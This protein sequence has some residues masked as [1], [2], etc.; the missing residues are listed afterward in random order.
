[1]TA[2][3]RAKHRLAL[4]QLATRLRGQANR[5]RIARIENNSTIE[6][7]EA[8]IWALKQTGGETVEAHDMTG[9]NQ[10]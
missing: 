9:A 7:V 10:A 3:D 5:E 8:L 2:A 1:M 6:A 4:W